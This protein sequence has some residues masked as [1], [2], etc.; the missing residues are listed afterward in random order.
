MYGGHTNIINLVSLLISLGQSEE[1][2]TLKV[3]IKCRISA[4]FNC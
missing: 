3:Q 2:T 4:A 1:E